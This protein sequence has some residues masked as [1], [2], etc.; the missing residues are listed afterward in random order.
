MDDE[1]E[2][3]GTNYGRRNNSSKCNVTTVH[4]INQWSLILYKHTLRCSQ[5]IRIS[6]LVTGT[7][8]GRYDCA[9]DVKDDKFAYIS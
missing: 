3:D 5:E 9:R 7:L 6:G 2:G 1:D 8:Y 4:R